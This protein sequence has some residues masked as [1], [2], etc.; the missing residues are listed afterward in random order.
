MDAEEE[1]LIEEVEEEGEEEEED[2][3]LDQQPVS[4]PQRNLRLAMMD[5]AV[6]SATPIVNYQLLLPLRK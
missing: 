4:T 2:L 3:D 6:S 5:K 1:E